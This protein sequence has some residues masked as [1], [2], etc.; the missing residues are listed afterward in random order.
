MK[1]YIHIAMENIMKNL[2]F[3]IYIIKMIVR[4]MI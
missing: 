2:K 3:K 4:I 1:T